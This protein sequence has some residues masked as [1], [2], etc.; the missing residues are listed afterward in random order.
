MPVEEGSRIP[1]YTEIHTYA[2]LQVGPMGSRHKK[3]IL[4]IHGLLMPGILNFRSLVVDV[5]PTNR[6]GLLDSLEKY[7]RGSGLGTFKPVLFPGQLDIY[8]F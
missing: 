7:M 8:I 2:N 3:S 6:K 5:K 4:P 1:S